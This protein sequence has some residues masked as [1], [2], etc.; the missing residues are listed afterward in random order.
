MSFIKT[1]YKNSSR[2]DIAKH[3]QASQ[4]DIKMMIDDS[5]LLIS[6]VDNGHG[7]SDNHADKGNGLKNME[8]R[9]NAIGG[10]YSRKTQPEGGVLT[11]FSIPTSNLKFNDRG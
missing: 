5:I 7:L 10:Q 3:A 1:T 8:K 9:M 6:I 2:P 11:T 4:V